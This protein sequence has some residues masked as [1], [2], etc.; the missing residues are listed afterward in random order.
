LSGKILLLNVAEGRFPGTGYYGPQ[1]A[2]RLRVRLD[3]LGLEDIGMSVRNVGGG[4]TKADMTLVKT[5]RTKTEREAQSLKAYGKG[6]NS[7][8]VGGDDN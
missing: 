7:T 5:T 4:R 3:K 2:K 8:P 6:K 1:L